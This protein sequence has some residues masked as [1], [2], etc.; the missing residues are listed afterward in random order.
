MDSSSPS[1]CGRFTFGRSATPGL[2]DRNG[3]FQGN[4]LSCICIRS[5][6]SLSPMTGDDL[7]ASSAQASVTARHQCLRLREFD[8]CLFIRRRCRLPLHPWR[9]FLYRSAL[10][11]WWALSALLY[12]AC[13]YVVWH[14]CPHLPDYGGTVLLLAVAFPGFFNLIAWGQTSAIALACFTLLFFLLRDRREFLAGLALGCL[15]FKPQLGLAAAIVFIAIGA[16]KTI[17]GTVISAAAQLLVG[18]AYYGAEPLRKWMETVWNLSSVL[19]SSNQDRIRHI[20]CERSGRCSCPGKA[21]L[22]PC[23]W[24]A[25]SLSLSPRLLCGSADPECLCLCDSPP[26]CW[27]RCWFLHI[28][29]FTIS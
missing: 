12:G 23:T 1:R 4:G 24:L 15:I 22:S 26:C 5:V 13:C 28:S 11:L 14:A 6:R 17:G 3:E 2:R 9:I 16:W 8:I 25:H 18:V 19:P 20:A 7:S 10:A 21:Y 27:L 29:P